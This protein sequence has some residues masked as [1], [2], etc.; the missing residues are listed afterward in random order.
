MQTPS[1]WSLVLVRLFI[2]IGAALTAGV[3]FG[4]PKLWVIGVLA[5]YL[6]WNLY[7]AFLLDR[8]LNFRRGKRPRSAAGVWGRIYTG[9][10]RLANRGRERKRRLNRVLKE[11]RKATGAMPDASVVLNGENEIVWLNDVASDYLG[12]TKADRGRRI[13]YFLRDPDFVEYL[14]RENFDR[15]LP[16]VSPVN[17]GR[18]LSVRI[19]AYGQDQRLLLAKDV[20]RERRLEKIRRDFVGNASHELRSPLTV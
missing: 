2:A 10:Y 6:G 19:I 14:R 12:I 17:G 18:T 8:W 15:P 11:F 4:Y 5:A 13:D 7:H 20:T 3:V 1:A 9:I 16:L